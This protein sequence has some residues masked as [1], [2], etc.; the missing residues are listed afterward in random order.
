MLQC[1][2]Q[3][4]I[5]MLTPFAGLQVIGRLIIHW[6]YLSFIYEFFYGY[7][8]ALFRA[9]FFIVVFFQYYI[10]IVI[11]IAFYNVFPRYFFTGILVDTGITYVSMVM[12]VQHV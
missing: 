7:H 12:L 6:V 2:S 4:Y 3:Q 10:L 5:S 1:F 11:Q 8:L 9:G